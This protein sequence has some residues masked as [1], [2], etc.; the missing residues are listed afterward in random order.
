MSQR[1]R[2]DSVKSLAGLRSISYR[3]TG[4]IN[5]E[6]ETVEDQEVLPERIR[7]AWIQGSHNTKI[8]MSSDGTLVQLKGNPGRFGRSDNVFNRDWDGT[9][10]VCNQLLNSQGL[11]AFDVGEPYASSELIYDLDGN[12]ASRPEFKGYMVSPEEGAGHEGARVWSI[13]VT[14][15]FIAGSDANALAVIGWLDSQ[16]VARV[17]KQRFGK[18]TV[19]WGHLRYCQVE[20]YLKADEMLAHCKGEIERE[21]MR[22]NPVYQW[23]RENG[24]VRVEVK[25]AKDCLRDMGLTWAGEWTMNKVIQLFEARTELL[26]RVKTDIEEFDPATLPSR[27]ALTA[28]AWLRGADVRRSMSKVTFW[29]HAKVLREYGIDIAEPRNVFSMPVRIKTIELQSAVAPDWYWEQSL[30]RRV[31]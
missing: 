19:V 9:L 14:R 11:P 24:V 31:A 25:A 12:L 29:R 5:H 28:E 20:A 26:H 22:Q 23:C 13:H 16:S 3:E 6:G 21:Q 1:F 15:N 17:K 27:V 7:S 18:S 10:A 4:D 8:Q 2:P 30:R